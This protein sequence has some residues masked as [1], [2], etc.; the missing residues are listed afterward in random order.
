MDII[1]HYRRKVSG[2]PLK[3]G[4]S[5]EGSYTVRK[6]SSDNQS[7]GDGGSIA[8]AGWGTFMLS[9]SKGG[10]RPGD[11]EPRGRCR[12]D[13]RSSDGIKPACVSPGTMS[14][15]PP[16]GVA[17][18]RFFLFPECQNASSVMAPRA[19]VA[20]WDGVAAF[21]APALPCA[22]PKG[23]WDFNEEWGALLISPVAKT[24]RTMLAPKLPT[25]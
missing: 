4:K 10:Q 5:A 23:I 6:K 3:S 17:I 9:P 15:G 11:S 16:K 1:P 7:G 20:A 14:I 21:A 18:A 8:L 25:R 22:L 24:T 13:P 2:S 12:F 19:E